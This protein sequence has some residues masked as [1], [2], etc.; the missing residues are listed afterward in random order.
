MFVS[1]QTQG[2]HI[3]RTQV[4]SSGYG[5]LEPYQVVHSE[6]GVSRFLGGTP[7]NMS[8]LPTLCLSGHLPSAYA[9]LRLRHKGCRL[10]PGL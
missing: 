10:D 9:P 3:P 5:F 8:H 2:A 7:L 1:S 4:V 6:S